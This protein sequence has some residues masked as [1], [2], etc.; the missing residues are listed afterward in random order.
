MRSLHIKYNLSLEIKVVKTYSERKYIHSFISWRVDYHFKVSEK[1]RKY[2]RK[3]TV[4]SYEGFPTAL[5]KT[6]SHFMI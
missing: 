6:Q 3:K 4:L 5:I 1:E 2:P